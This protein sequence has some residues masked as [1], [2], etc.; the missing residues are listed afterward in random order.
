MKLRMGEKE[1]KTTNPNI[2]EWSRE[3]EEAY[4]YPDGKSIVLNMKKLQPKSFKRF[5]KRNPDAVKAMGRF[6]ISRDA[7]ANKS[8]EV[9]Q[10]LDYFMEFYDPDKEL[11]LAYANLKKIID[12]RSDSITSAEYVKLLISRLILETNIR[13]RLYELVEDCYDYDVTVD[14]NGREY[15]GPY[16]FTNDE[17]KLLLAIAFMMK[18]VIPPTEHY[19]STNTIYHGKE[20]S[21]LMCDIFSEIFYMVGDKTEEGESDTLLIKLYMYT[22]KQVVK[23]VKGNSRLW[24]QENALRGVTDASH[25]DLL[26]VKYL[27]SDNFFKARFYKNIV[28]FIKS[29]IETQLHFTIEITPYRKNPVALDFS[30]GPEGLSNIDKIEQ[31]QS[32]IDESQSIRINL[33][34]DDIVEKLKKKVGPISDEEIEFYQKY[35]I[36]SDKFHTDLLRNYFAKYFDGYSSQKLTNALTNVELTIIA[37][38]LMEK[39]GYDQLQFLMSSVPHG[40]VS[41]RQLRNK[42]F[43]DKFKASEKYQDLMERKYKALKGYSDDEPITMIS[44]VLNN[45]FRFVDYD[46]PE[47]TGEEIPFDEDIISDEILTF[48]DGI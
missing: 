44:M 27:L 10:Y 35:P 20:L 17:A 24:D 46:R 31:L 12:S 37:K 36:Q 6:N 43:I 29:V 40:K 16:D 28:S 26:I 9:C 48:I 34:I 33:T 47:L 5:E 41:R 14:K 22:I 15:H 8:D 32:K 1:M 23:H 7:F 13:Q 39:D 30:S 25:T 18:M 38:R 19:I 3:P 4:V 11:P 45:T 21:G 42:K 2:D